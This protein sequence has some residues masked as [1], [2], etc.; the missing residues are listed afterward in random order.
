MDY[1]TRTAVIATGISCLVL[2]ETS[3]ADL[4]FAAAVSKVIASC[5]F[6]TVAVLS[7]ALRSTYGRILLAGLSFSFIGDVLLIGESQRL[8]L[9]GLSAFLLAHVAYIGAFVAV[10]VSLR[11]IITAA[12]PI[13]GIA[14][15]VMAWL[16]PHLPPELVLPV[17]LYT[18]VISGMVIAAFGTRGLGASTMILAGA[19]M[20][21]LSDLSVASLRILQTEIPTY[22]WG[23][24]LYYGGQLC[25]AL[26]TSQSRSH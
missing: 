19:L 13:I 2:V 17:Y 1:R 21:F 10:G 9:G 18:A 15:A 11:W 22:I 25:L 14:I 8:F 16:A 6:I 23:L 3:L 5:G 4:H 12:L 7:G 20:F 26:S 24:P